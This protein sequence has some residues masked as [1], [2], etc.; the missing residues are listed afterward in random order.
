MQDLQREWHLL[1]CYGVICLVLAVGDGTPR[2]FFKPIDET[3]TDGRKCFAFGLITMTSFVSW[4]MAKSIQNSSKLGARFGI[5]GGLA[6]AAWFVGVFTTGVIVY[7]LRKQGYYSLP[8][9]INDRYGPLACVVFALTV[10]Y[11]LFNEVWSNTVVIA[12]F[13][14]DSL[15]FDWKLAA[16]VSMGIPAAYT[17]IGGMRASLYS[18]ALQAVLMCVLLA[19]TYFRITS[20]INDNTDLKTYLKDNHNSDSLWFYN[21]V[22]GREKWSLEGGLDLLFTGLLQGAL[23]YTFMDPALTDRAFLASKE[24][25]VAGFAVGS[26][27]A[28][29]YI[30]VFGFIG[31][32]GN[33]LGECVDAGACP[34]SDLRGADVAGVSAGEPSAVGT[35]LGGSYYTLLCLV[36]ITSA[37]STLDSTFSS[38]AKVAGP[39]LH[40]YITNGRPINPSFA[41]ERDVLIGRIA[42]VVI[43][44]TGT[45]PLLFDPDEL[46]ATTVTGTMVPGLGPP[47]YMAAFACL[48]SSKFSGR[49]T[50]R[51]RPLMFLL[52]FLFSAAIGTCYQMASQSENCVPTKVMNCQVPEWSNSTIVACDEYS[53]YFACRADSGCWRNDDMHE[54]LRVE[55][56]LTAFSGHSCNLP[57]KDTRNNIKG[58]FFTI[59]DLNGFNIGGGS[60]KNL[61]G[62]NVVSAIGALFLFLFACGDDFLTEKFNAVKVRVENE[63]VEKSSAQSEKFNGEQETRL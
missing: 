9:F 18:D 61:F 6:Y 32:Y 27:L 21:P 46:D 57:C 48:F 10:L 31:V 59:V 43:G 17:L 33:M 56:E 7:F 4:V 58:R 35:A 60:Y 62:V 1:N 63:E 39:D 44:V 16:W 25:M 26:M 22:K 34:T 13:F 5:V 20:D 36:I 2:Q 23:S 51:T 38:V 52:P 37:L 24:V 11:R 29:A 15:S 54:C 53:T 28:M 14:G 30:T 50:T 45:L 49:V 19:M 42:I 41:T 47:I 12:D 8:D 3:N 40:G 55:S